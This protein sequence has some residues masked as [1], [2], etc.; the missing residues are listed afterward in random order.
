MIQP[1]LVPRPVRVEAALVDACRSMQRSPD[2][3]GLGSKS[4]A[5][6]EPV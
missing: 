3:H 2:L 6:E 1:P 4:V 5:V